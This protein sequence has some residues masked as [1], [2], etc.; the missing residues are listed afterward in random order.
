MDPVVTILE[1]GS[2]RTSFQKP[3]RIRKKKQQSVD[4][5]TCKQFDVI[6]KN[7][8]G[9]T[10]SILANRSK[11]EEEKLQDEGNTFRTFVMKDH[12]YGG[13]EEEFKEKDNADSPQRNSAM[14]A[15][16]IANSAD[17]SSSDQQSLQDYPIRIPIRRDGRILLPL[18]IL[19][20]T[21][22]W[23]V[24]ALVD[25]GATI[26]I[27][28]EQE[29]ESFSE[30][31]RNKYQQVTPRGGFFRKIRV[32]KTNLNGPFHVKVASAYY[33]A[34]LSILIRIGEAKNLIT[35]H[36]V[37][38]VKQM[39]GK[40][41]LGADFLREYGTNIY[42]HSM[43]TVYVS[44]R[45]T[46]EMVT[47]SDSNSDSMKLPSVEGEKLKDLNSNHDVA[48]THVVSGAI[49]NDAPTCGRLKRRCNNVNVTTGTARR[50]YG[51]I[52]SF[53]GRIARI[54]S[55]IYS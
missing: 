36:T 27:I 47:D 4:N 6:K 29:L 42:Y 12:G 17:N 21:F 1:R 25:T 46:K 3:T 22:A 2:V 55:R 14:V 33:K 9:L 43:D 26:S 49:A 34:N 32:R 44:M 53:V 54:D 15:P 45:A 40:L 8:S 52:R 41:I 37:Y 35:F 51:E 30:I 39:V 24:D 18:R 48:G 50:I 7:L 20:D 23:P 38:V 31:L 13:P 11:K 28:N 16:L 5:G 10:G 19:H